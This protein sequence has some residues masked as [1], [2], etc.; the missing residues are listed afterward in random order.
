MIFFRNSWLLYFL[1]LSILP[2]ILHLLSLKRRKNVQFTYVHLINKIVNQY[3]P[4]K[5][6]VELLVLILRCLII[7]LILIFF[8]GPVAY[9]SPKRYPELNI[10]ILLDNSFSMRQKVGNETKFELCKKSIK[11][12]L[13]QLRMYNI[14]PTIII[15]NEKVTQLKKKI[16][17]EETFKELDD[18]KVTYNGTNLSGVLEYLFSLLQYDHSSVN[19]VLIFTDLAEHLVS[20]NIFISTQTWKNKNVD[21]MFCYPKIDIRNCYTENLNII[22]KEDVVEI[23]YKLAQSGP[24]EA[25]PVKL[26]LGDT[27]VDNMTISN[28]SNSYS[29]RYLFDR[30]LQLNNFGYLLLPSD[31]LIED[32][33][34]YFSFIDIDNRYGKVLCL[35]NEPLT[36]YG[37]KSKK[38]YFDKLKSIGIEVDIK[39]YY[40]EFTFANIKPAGYTD[41]IFVGLPRI[42]IVSDLQ[43]ENSQVIIFPSEQS[44]LDN[45]DQVL[46]GLEFIRLQKEDK[47]LNLT[48]G[49]DDIWND[50]VSRFEYDKIIVSQRFIL[51]IR[52]KNLWKVLLRYSDST[53]AIV[54]NRNLYVFSFNPDIEWSNFVLK[55]IFIGF[56]DKVLRQDK[57]QNKKYKN[58]Y[59]TSEE[60]FFDEP[61]QK[62][63]NIYWNELYCEKTYS[64]V[65]F[66]QPGV[67]EVNTVKDKFRIAVNT[68]AEESNIR[69]ANEVKLRKMLSKVVRT[70]IFFA[71]I[72]KIKMNKILQWCIGKE[73]TGTVAILLTIFFILET[74]L[75]RLSKKLL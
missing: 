19:K 61:I 38:F 66:Y 8:S 34:F 64:G 42:D 20:E 69:L 47:K 14:I 2:I 22:K 11:D 17:L 48:L 59:Y 74:I 5:K 28:F 54:N 31:G 40:D 16:Y 46:D 62:I 75:S 12:I 26:Y 73:L 7:F 65:K 3:L 23:Q 43:N 58:Y 44:D 9:F 25:I 67:Y 13:T 33:K 53:P 45:Y 55:P 30:K 1:P 21:I 39:N 60:I 50:Y 70:N 32:N 68:P 63:E 71:D 41:F 37:V 57:I 6:I 35:I 49:E 27:V 4:R 10:F 51:T 29:F 52:D 56:F 18:I 36:L 24:V 15:F 72:N